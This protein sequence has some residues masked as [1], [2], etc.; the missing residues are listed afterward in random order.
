LLITLVWRS[1]MLT[2]LFALE[3]QLELS[4]TLSGSWVTAVFHSNVEGPKYSSW[5]LVR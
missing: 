4:M 2:G 1:F 3:T 5:N